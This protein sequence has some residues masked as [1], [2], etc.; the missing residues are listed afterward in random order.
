MNIIYIYIWLLMIIMN[1]MNE[2][3]NIEKRITHTCIM[4]KKCTRSL[5]RGIDTNTHDISILILIWRWERVRE[6]KWFDNMP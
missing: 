1:E 6:G 4:M 3:L 2:K 5:G